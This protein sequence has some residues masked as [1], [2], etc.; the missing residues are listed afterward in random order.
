MLS[1]AVHCKPS[2]CANP[3]QHAT[4][5]RRATIR[6]LK[7]VCNQAFILC[8]ALQFRCNTPY[9]A[10]NAPSPHTG[11]WMLGAGFPFT[12]HNMSWNSCRSGMSSIFT[13]RRRCRACL[14]PCIW[15]RGLHW[16]A[17][18]PSWTG[19]A[20]RRSGLPVAAGPDEDG[21]RAHC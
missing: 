6:H 3:V 2:N 5:G 8:R 18:A 17:R 11:C 14:S 19:Y 13:T 4:C 20:C 15:T 21:C 9:K 7:V 16:T 12:K 10:S 1:T